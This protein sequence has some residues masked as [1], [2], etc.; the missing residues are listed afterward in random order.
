M[1]SVGVSKSLTTSAEQKIDTA[2]MTFKALHD[3][4]AD[5]R[6]VIA[7]YYALLTLGSISQWE[8]VPQYDT[9]QAFTRPWV[10]DRV[11]V[12]QAV[13]EPSG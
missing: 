9:L 10:V 11:A 5:V 6:G 8:P 1:R 7:K 4:I 2:A 3:A 13:K 12:Q